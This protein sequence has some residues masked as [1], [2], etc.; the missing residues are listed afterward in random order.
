MSVGANIKAK[1][2]ALNLTQRELAQ[3]VNVD[4]SMICQIERGT[5]MPTLPL[6]KEI[7]DALGCTIEE[8]IA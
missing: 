2:T 6:G 4:P 7:A 5:K 3:R 8:L 1:R